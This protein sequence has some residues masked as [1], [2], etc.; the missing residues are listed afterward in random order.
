MKDNVE[1]R[2]RIKAMPDLGK[3]LDVVDNTY[4]EFKDSKDRTLRAKLLKDLFRASIDCQS[5]CKTL[6]ELFGGTVF[7]DPLPGINKELAKRVR[8]S[9]A[10]DLHNCFNTL[11]ILCKN[12][13]GISTT[14][15]ALQPVQK[16]QEQLAQ[17]RVQLLFQMF[18]TL[19]DLAELTTLTTAEP[20]K[21]LI[22]H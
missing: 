1:D 17:E 13:V 19:G 16:T 5:D 7:E 15:R 14:T 11:T 6:I 8:K 10:N 2:L 21:D 9:T 22:A 18:I 4:K 20:E 3:S 12:F